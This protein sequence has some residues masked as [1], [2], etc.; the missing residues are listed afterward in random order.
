MQDD[1]AEDDPCCELRGE[2]LY[3]IKRK[4]GGGEK[5]T[6]LVDLASFCKTLWQLAHATPLGG[7]LE[8]NK[9]SAKISHSF[10]V[11]LLRLQEEVTRRCATCLEC[12]H[13]REDKPPR[14]SLQVMPVLAISFSHIALDIVGF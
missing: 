12:Q 14:A 3:W 4:V 9:T 10:G 7:H 13:T 2:L 6:R 1:F 11:F 5:I 8:R